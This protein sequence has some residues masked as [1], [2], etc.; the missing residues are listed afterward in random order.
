MTVAENLAF[1]LRMRKVAKPA[2]R[3]RVEWALGLVQLEGLGGRYPRQLSGGQQQKECQSRQENFMVPQYV[4]F[5][6]EL[7][8]TT[9]GK[10]KKTE[11]S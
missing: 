1:P 10:I 4:V 11:L 8:K 6:N 2:I 3:E 7:P 5:V 9:T